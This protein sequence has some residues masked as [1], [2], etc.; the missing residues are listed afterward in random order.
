MKFNVEALFISQQLQSHD[1][2]LIQLK[3]NDYMPLTIGSR[4][5]WQFN[6][7]WLFNQQ[8]VNLALLSD[9]RWQDLTPN[10]PFKLELRQT[11]LAFDPQPHQLWL[12][13]NLS[14]AAV[15][16]AA[17]RWQNSPRPKGQFMALLSS[18]EGFVFQPKPA[19]FMLNFAPQVIAASALLEDFGV[20]NRL[21]TPS[22]LP[23]C[24]E[25]D[26]AELYQTW[27]EAHHHQAWSI[28]GWLPRKQQQQCLE[29]TQLYNTINFQLQSLP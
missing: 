20:P 19:R 15:F 25:G 22:G 4:L 10:Q 9:Q 12:G 7:A 18:D 24:W 2:W 14:Q 13:H 17:K 8:N 26:I 23:G 11:E 29:L 16:D 6:Q 1:G 28:Y 3:L 21:A 27:L 5:V